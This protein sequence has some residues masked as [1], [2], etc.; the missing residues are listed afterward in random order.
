MA[1]WQAGIDAWPR[2]VR[3][4]NRSAHCP[5]RHIAPS[6]YMGGSQKYGPFLCSLHIRCRIIV[7]IQ[8]GTI[9]LTTSHRYIY[10]ICLSIHVFV[11]L[12]FRV[13]SM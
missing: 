2:L 3:R 13:G 4:A 11:D 12:G 6:V 10:I 7:G 5:C 1:A 8:K 9:I